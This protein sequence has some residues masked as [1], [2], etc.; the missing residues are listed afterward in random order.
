MERSE[1]N[2]KIFEYVSLAS[3]VYSDYSSEQFLIRLTFF[4]QFILAF[5]NTEYNTINN[6]GAF[7][8]ARIIRFYILGKVKEECDITRL[9]FTTCL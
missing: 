7:R 6:Y 9:I 8:V 5:H 4:S 2:S 3:M 1:L